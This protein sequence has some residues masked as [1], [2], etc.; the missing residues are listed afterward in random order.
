MM[1]RKARY[2]LLYFLVYPPLYLLSMLP[3]YLSNILI[4]RLL[5]FLSYRV[6][7]YRYNVVLQNLS[8]ALP[9][10]TYEEVELLAREFYLHLAGLAVEITRF[11]SISSREQLKQVRISNPE[12]LD[13]YYQQNRNVIAVLG[14]YGNWECLN[15]LPML[16]PFQVNAIYKPLSNKI[17][18]KLVHRIR[19]RFGMRMIPASQALRQLLKT[20]EQPQLSLFIADQFPGLQAKCRVDFMNQSTLMFNGAEKLAIATNSVVIYIDI[21]PLGHNSWRVNFSTITETAPQ[22]SSGQITAAFSKK[23]Q[24]TISIS[25]AYWLWSHKRWKEN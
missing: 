20:H 1:T 3:Y 13:T 11:F 15:I 6:F 21:L 25:P 8:R 12:L 14:H 22:T 18:G 23:L 5:F 16:L 4:G 2:D 24:Q 9:L 17:M 10:K 7:R 19:T